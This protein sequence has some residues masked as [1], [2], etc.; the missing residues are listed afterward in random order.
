MHDHELT[1]KPIVLDYGLKGVTLIFF[2]AIVSNYTV[3]LLA[4]I[5][6]HGAFTLFFDFFFILIQLETIKR[7]LALTTN[8]QTVGFLNQVQ[9]GYC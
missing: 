4:M 8:P 2:N 1:A 3:F 6:Q 7:R 5:R 9:G